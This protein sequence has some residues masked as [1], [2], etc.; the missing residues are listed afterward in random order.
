M[1]AQ[2][3]TI[4]EISKPVLPRFATL[5]VH[6]VHDFPSPFGV[7]LVGEYTFDTMGY[8]EIRVFARVFVKNYQT[9]PI[10]PGKA[11][12]SLMVCHGA[13]LSSIQVATKKVVSTV[14]GEISGSLTDKLLGPHTRLLITAEH[15]PPGPYT[16]EVTYYLLP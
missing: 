10:P 12:L 16:V 7:P 6:D 4:T 3:F 15:M 8:S 1:P 13:G 9:T 14:T 2:P 11:T 5:A